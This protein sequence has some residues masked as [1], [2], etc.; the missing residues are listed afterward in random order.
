M[1]FYLQKDL[2][3]PA[4]FLYRD[5]IGMISRFNPIWL[6]KY[7]TLIAWDVFFSYLKNGRVISLDIGSHNIPNSLYYPVL[8]GV[9][10]SGVLLLTQNEQDKPYFNE[11]AY[12]VPWS[13]DERLLDFTK[14]ECF[15]D[16]L[17]IPFFSTVVKWHD[18][19]ILSWRAPTLFCYNLD[20]S[21]LDSFKLMTHAVP[22]E[23]D[24]FS[25]SQ[26][27][28]FDG[29]IALISHYGEKIGFD[30]RSKKQFAVPDNMTS[31]WLARKG[32]LVYAVRSSIHP[33]RTEYV[34]ITYDLKSRT[35]T[36]V[37]PFEQSDILEEIELPVF[38]LW[39]NHLIIWTRHQW[40][41]IK[42]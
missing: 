9:S 29:E 26:L 20:A 38:I 17:G 25:V 18:N 35:T 10:K 33:D 27:F 14:A 5:T 42:L 28:F 41:W 21:A 34:L 37:L 24:E 13:N 3:E 4:Q 1:T 36:D 7:G 19:L 22:G 40:K 2:S 23:Y 31:Q 15:T 12:F 30:L 6:N 11:A 16:S 39:P 32:D 8:C